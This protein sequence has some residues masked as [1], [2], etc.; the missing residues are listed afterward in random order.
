MGR[1]TPKHKEG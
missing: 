1:D